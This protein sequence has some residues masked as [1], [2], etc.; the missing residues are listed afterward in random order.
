MRHADYRS[1]LRAKSDG[2]L[3][4]ICDGNV[5]LSQ[6]WRA[7]RYG[8]DFS[9]LEGRRLGVVGEARSGRGRTWARWLMTN[10]CLWC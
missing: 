9:S 1:P 6:A 3:Y 10:D 5:K 4:R 8:E 7:A 2:T